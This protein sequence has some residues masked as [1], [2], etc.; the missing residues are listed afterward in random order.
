[1]EPAAIC[2]F[3]AQRCGLQA[4]F[5][6]IT[7]KYGDL[8]PLAVFLTV[9]GFVYAIHRQQSER[10]AAAQGAAT[11]AA[12]SKAGLLSAMAAAEL[13]FTPVEDEVSQRTFAA[14]V[15][16]V[17]SKFTGLTGISA[18]YPNGHI[19]R[20]ASAVLG[21]RGADPLQNP[22]IGAAFRRAQQT[23]A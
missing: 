17:T 18:V 23:R 13:Q 7:S 10:S 14:A 1:M 15:D 20:G 3:L 21:T 5:R 19:R 16:T 8:V 6:W 22:A 9:M 11:T 12:E 2:R 4:M